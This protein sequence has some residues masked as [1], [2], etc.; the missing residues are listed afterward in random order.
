MEI[1]GG[2]E[3]GSILSFMEGHLQMGK[4][5]SPLLN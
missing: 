2:V 3:N 4:I 1:R 5:K